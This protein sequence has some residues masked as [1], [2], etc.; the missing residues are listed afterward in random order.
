[1]DPLAPPLTES[2]H[3]T[4]MNPQTYDKRQTRVL[5]NNVIMRKSTRGIL[6]FEIVYLEDPGQRRLEDCFVMMPIVSKKGLANF[7]S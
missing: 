1:M 3:L 2:L 7:V 5:Y 4:P 6:T